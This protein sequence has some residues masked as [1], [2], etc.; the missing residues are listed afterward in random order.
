MTVRVVLPEDFLPG[1]E[2]TYYTYD[3]DDFGTLRP[4]NLSEY[5]KTKFT[6]LDG[7]LQRQLYQ[8]S[9]PTIRRKL[10][11]SSK[12]T[13]NLGK[14]PIT[15]ATK[16][17]FHLGAFFYPEYPE[18]PWPDESV[19][20]AL[21]NYDNVVFYV[22]FSVEFKNSIDLSKILRF[23]EF[24]VEEVTLKNFSE[25]PK[26]YEAFMT[27]NVTVA[28]FQYCDIKM[29][30]LLNL[31][32]NIERLSLKPNPESDWEDLFDCKYPLNDVYIVTSKIKNWKN[33][34]EFLKRQGNSIKFHFHPF[35]GMIS[36]LN[37]SEKEKAMEYFNVIDCKKDPRQP[38]ANSIC[39]YPK[40]ILYC[41]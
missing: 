30:T 7:V 38:N 36:D 24:D 39:W 12:Q 14:K 21:K 29:N 27:S 23:I 8:L 40:Y 19:R 35:H 3:E 22:V 20:V 25:L 37:D 28:S 9:F 1:Y 26:G 15:R 31:L 4:K 17:F 2:L 16:T 34:S 13:S 6:K 41:K 10:W 18:V 32:P 5:S 33:F 11:L